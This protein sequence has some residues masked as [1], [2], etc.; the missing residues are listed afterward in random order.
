LAQFELGR[1][2][3]GPPVATKTKRKKADPEV[4]AYY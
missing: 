2:S 4:I 1:E 3:G